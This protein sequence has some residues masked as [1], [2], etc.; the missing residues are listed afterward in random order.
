MAIRAPDGA[1][2]WQCQKMYLFIYVSLNSSQQEI[3]L[4]IPTQPKH[5]ICGIFFHSKEND[6]WGLTTAGLP[7]MLGCGCLEG[8]HQAQNIRVLVSQAKPLSN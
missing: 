3:K 8:G 7:L 2:K 6:R 4:E 5:I 1:N